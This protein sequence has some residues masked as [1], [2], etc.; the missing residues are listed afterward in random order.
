MRG[1]HQM[2]GEDDGVLEAAR[3]IRPYLRDLIGP[4]AA[5]LPIS[6]S[7]LSSPGQRTVRSRS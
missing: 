6:G 7:P 3:A 1:E 2:E 4:T 5:G